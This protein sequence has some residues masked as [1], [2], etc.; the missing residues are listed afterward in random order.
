M[1][2]HAYCG[3]DRGN[4]TPLNPLDDIFA[5]SGETNGGVKRDSAYY[6]WGA[7]TLA[8]NPLIKSCLPLVLRERK[9]RISQE[10]CRVAVLDYGNG[11][12]DNKATITIG[13]WYMK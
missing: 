9:D 1:E 12:C 10:Q 13:G 2:Q 4:A 11:V 3:S 7:R 5:V 6:Q 8:D